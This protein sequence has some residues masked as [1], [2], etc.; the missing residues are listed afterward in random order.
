MNQLIYRQ[1]GAVPEDKYRRHGNLA[2]VDP[3]YYGRPGKS[4]GDRHTYYSAP[5]LTVVFLK[6]KTKQFGVD[7]VYLDGGQSL[8]GE[9][10]LNTATP[11]P[12]H[13]SP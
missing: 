11:L 9:V 8:I 2:A 4:G 7:F 6:Y 10:A 12:P 1:L 13:S 3:A 5:T